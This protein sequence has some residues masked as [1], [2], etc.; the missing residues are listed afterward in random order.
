MT[1]YSEAS[2]LVQAILGLTVGD[3]ASYT[4]PNGK[5]IAVSITAVETY[6]G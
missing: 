3:E 6:S 1:V 2:P 5:Q 4:A